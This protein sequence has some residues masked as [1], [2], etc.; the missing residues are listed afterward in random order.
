MEK[1]RKMGEGKYFFFRFFFLK[2]TN[3]A[4]IQNFIQIPQK[5]KTGVPNLFKLVKVTLLL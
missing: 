2:E 3:D 5:I 1:Q 4:H